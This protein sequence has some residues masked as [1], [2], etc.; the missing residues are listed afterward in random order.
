MKENI[1]FGQKNS[2]KQHS[3][4][5]VQILGEIKIFLEK[6]MLKENLMKRNSAYKIVMLSCTKAKFCRHY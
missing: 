5:S 2:G 3:D 6:K 1:P 4:M